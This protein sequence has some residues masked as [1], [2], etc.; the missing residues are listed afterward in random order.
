MLGQ[1]CYYYWQLFNL[2]I[3]EKSGS[4]H[5]DKATEAYTC[6]R[7]TN[8]GL[9][10]HTKRSRQGVTVRWESDEKE[11][12]KDAFTFHNKC[13]RLVGDVMQSCARQPQECLTSEELKP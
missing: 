3:V 11:E 9:L 7:E 12:K 10:I 5:R 13:F 1:C 8:N 2:G 4:W 6:P